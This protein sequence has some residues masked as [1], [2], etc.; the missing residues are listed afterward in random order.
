M[1]PRLPLCYEFCHY[2]FKNRSLPA[3]LPVHSFPQKVESFFVRWFINAELFLYILAVEEIWPVCELQLY[4]RSDNTLLFYF[5]V[6][7]RGGS[8]HL[9][10]HAWG[11]ECVMSCWLCLYNYNGQFVPGSVPCIHSYQF[12]NF[13]WEVIKWNLCPGEHCSGSK[14]LAAIQK[15]WLTACGPKGHSLLYWASLHADF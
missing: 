5:L 15:G 2:I 7:P 11:Y 8:S 10:W 4:S 9:A 14:T 1:M 3:L 13:H 12:L 6:L